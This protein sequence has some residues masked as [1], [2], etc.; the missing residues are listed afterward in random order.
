MEE[1]A[2]ITSLNNLLTSAGG[3]DTWLIEDMTDEIPSLLRDLAEV[4]ETSLE[5]AMAI[6]SERV[7]DPSSSPSIIYHLRLLASSWL[8]SNPSS[9]AGFIPDDLGVLGYRRNIIE[10]VNTEIDH[11]GMTLLI[12]V[13]LKPIGIKAEIVYLDRSEGSQA[14]S[15]IFQS[16]DS[17]GMP[18]NPDGPMIHLLYRPSHYDILYKEVTSA[19]DQEVIDGMALHSNIMVNRAHLN[20]QH[21][22]QNTHPNMSDYSQGVDLN[23]LLSIPGGYHNT[24]ASLTAYQSHYASPIDQTYAHSPMSSS[25]SPTSPGTSIA[26]PSSAAMSPTFSSQH[27]VSHSQSLTSPNVLRPSHIQSFPGPNAQM[28]IHTHLPTANTIPHRPSLSSNPSMEMPS[29][30]ATTSSFRPSKYEYTAAAEWQE[31]VVFQT[32]SFK[33]S[34][35]NTAH[36]NNPHFQPEE[37]NPDSEE[38]SARKK[39]SA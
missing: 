39:S 23:L 31:P 17:H 10:P 36:Y 38:Q 1:L 19:P 20:H 8:A 30:V 5:T 6:L 24:Q 22:I 12:D 21:H 28:P 33:N 11:L 7:N 14:N 4:V 16:E 35:F 27:P 18:T 15:H 25:L 32:S 13:L 29:P 9:Y 34:H 3:F 2:R 37:W 26:T